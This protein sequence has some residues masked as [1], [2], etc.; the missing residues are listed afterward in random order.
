MHK[1]AELKW[2]FL[3]WWGHKF[4]RSERKPVKLVIYQQ[5]N[6]QK[7]EHTN[8]EKELIYLKLPGK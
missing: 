6:F 7:R 4:K 5:S 1:Q 3:G 8:Q 2:V